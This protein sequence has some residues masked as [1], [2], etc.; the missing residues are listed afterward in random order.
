MKRILWFLPA[1]LVCLAAFWRVPFVWFRVDD[2]AWLSL[3]LDVHDAASLAARLFEPAAQGTI[4]VLSERLPFLALAS[5]F[6]VT[7]WPFRL[8]TLT[9]WFVALV[10]MQLVGQRLTGS[11]AAGLLAAMLW[12]VSA[13]LVTPLAWASAYNQVLLAVVVQGAFYARLCGRPRLE[14]A[15]FLAG[16]GVLESIIVYPALVLLHAALDERARAGWRRS[17]WMWI[18]AGAFALAHLLWIPKSDSPIY[19][20]ILDA[21]LPG[22][23][24]RY[25]E[26]TI[27]PSRMELRNPARQFQGLLVTWAIAFALAVFV[28]SR[29][30]R[31]QRT[32]AFLCGWFLLFLAPMLP[33]ANHVQDYYLAVPGIG[34]AWLGGW[35]V[36][37]GWQAGLATRVVA[38]ALALAYAAGS[39]AEIDSATSWYLRITSRIRL[40]YRAVEATLAKYPDSGLVL[41]GLDPE[42]FLNSVPH[43]PFRLLH[44]ERVWLEP[45]QDTVLDTAGDAGLLRHR[46]GSV[47]LLRQLE[48]GQVRVLD[49]SGG[50]PY[51]ITGAYRKALAARLLAQT[52]GVVDAGDLAYA[53]R[54]GPGWYAV[55][56]GSRWSAP[57]AE[58]ALY[59]APEANRLRISGYAPPEVLQAGPL[60]LSATVNGRRAGTATLR[61]SGQF[62]ADF[63]L[64]ARG[65]IRV[66]IAC[67]RA[68]RPPGDARELCLVFGR[69][70]GTP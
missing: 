9:T 62:T 26:W 37:A 18:P 61:A 4:R 17:L 32:P 70:Y 3:P 23:L 58:L 47:E 2:F 60:Q 45:E 69:F 30:R 51:D 5:L 1:P 14:A 7:S 50:A 52:R 31:G 43:R 64:A 40:M 38:V 25:L 53:S 65:W 54:L 19:Q 59:A 56:N 48:A 35:A 36:V 68:Y 27:G 16:F 22:N 13:V 55:E 49:V 67:N 44:A 29:L 46:I 10:L 21:R 11:R 42:V 34:L 39:V 63:P 8:L 12:S 41:A 66:E 33:L 24:W 28:Y 6:G 57:R 15:L 20:W